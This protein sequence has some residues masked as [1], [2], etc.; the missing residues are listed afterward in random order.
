MISVNEII[1]ILSQT[2]FDGSTTLA[3]IALIVTAWFVTLAILA[4]LKAPAEYSVVPMIPISIFFMSYNIL[5]TDV[6]MII[7]LI[8]CIITANGLRKI[9]SG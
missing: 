8:S 5:S 7:I 4:N 9:V 3:G 6:A 1:N 2:F